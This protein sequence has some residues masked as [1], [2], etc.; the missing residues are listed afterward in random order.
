M[1]THAAKIL[2][3]LMTII[4]IIIIM[5]AITIITIIITTAIAISMLGLVQPRTDLSEAGVEGCVL[6]LARWLNLAESFVFDIKHV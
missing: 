3:L 2:V 4:I 5:I 1:S 6:A